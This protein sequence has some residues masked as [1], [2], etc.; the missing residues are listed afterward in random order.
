M[1]DATTKFFEG[2][3]ARGHEPQLER[4]TGT[5]RFDL[6]NGKRSARWLVAIERG[7]VEVSHKN[8]KADC[9]VRA[10]K[11]LF[12]RIASGELNAF[13]A[14]LRGLMVLF[15]RLFPSPSSKSSSS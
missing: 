13:A 15:Q 9:V 14:A 1:A 11:A 12:D 8:L 7:D 3:E 4:V 2:L 10:E 5:L 6:T